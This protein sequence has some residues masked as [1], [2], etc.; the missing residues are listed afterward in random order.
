[1]AGFH[2]IRVEFIFG[3]IS[4]WSVRAVGFLPHMI[5]ANR[6]AGSKFSLRAAGIL[7]NWKG[8]E[9]IGRD[10]KGLD[11][12]GDAMRC[13]QAMRCC[14]LVSLRV[15]MGMGMGIRWADELGKLSRRLLRPVGNR[16]CFGPVCHCL[17]NPRELLV[18]KPHERRDAAA[19]G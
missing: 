12:D 5:A 17:K 6:G 2:C 19:E 1:M 18:F 11:G 9:G 3:R 7:A 10:W 15:G 4:Q 8:L 16:G 13:H 14:L